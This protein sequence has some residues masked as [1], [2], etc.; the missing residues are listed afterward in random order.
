MLPK[1]KAHWLSVVSFLKFIHKH[2]NITNVAKTR[3]FIEWSLKDK[4][5]FCIN[6]NNY[7][8]TDL[9]VLVFQRA[10]TS[11]STYYINPILL[12]VVGKEIGWIDKLPKDKTHWLSLSSFIRGINKQ[13]NSVNDTKLKL[14]MESSLRDKKEFFINGNNYKSTDLFGYFQR[15]KGAS[16]TY[17]INP[18]SIEVICKEIGWGNKPP[19]DGIERISISVM[20]RRL[21]LKNNGAVKLVRTLALELMQETHITKG[22]I[23]YYNAVGMGSGDGRGILLIDAQLVEL[24]REKLKIVPRVPEDR[25]HFLSEPQILAKSKSHSRKVYRQA[26]RE[27]RSAR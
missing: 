4:R 1:D 25:K 20:T 21:G 22:S 12:E 10:A 18:I 2:P 6:G 7:K 11:A 23:D 13:N 8:C 19:K 14:F 27:L 17:Y 9:F 15:E 3:L 5:E 26:L 16:S 24:F